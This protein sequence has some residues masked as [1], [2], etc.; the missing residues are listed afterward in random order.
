MNYQKSLEKQLP[1]S[2]A[3]SSSA[4]PASAAAGSSG[5]PSTMAGNQVGTVTAGM[6]SW[7]ALTFHTGMKTL[8]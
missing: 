7:T 1:A 4:R 2:L 6:S 8:F 5:S 3:S